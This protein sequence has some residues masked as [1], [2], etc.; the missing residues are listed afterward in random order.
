MRGIL[1]GA[2][3]QLI[4]SLETLEGSHGIK[5]YLVGGILGNLYTIFRITQDIDFVVDIESQDIDYQIL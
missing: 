3:E 5:Y 2:L 4:N 1:Q